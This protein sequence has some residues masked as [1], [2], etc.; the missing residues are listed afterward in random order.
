MIFSST[1]SVDGGWTSGASIGL[2]GVDTGAGAIDY[3][4]KE[5]TYYSAANVAWEGDGLG[6]N[7]YT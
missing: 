5:G 7:Y 4:G 3:P 2:T 1:Y 6:M